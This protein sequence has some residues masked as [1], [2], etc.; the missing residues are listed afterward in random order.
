MD[1]LK[2]SKSKKQATWKQEQQTQKAP[3]FYIITPTKNDRK[4]N[5]LHRSIMW[6]IQ[7][8]LPRRVHRRKLQRQTKQ[9]RLHKLMHNQRNMDD[10]KNNSRNSKKSMNT[11][12]RP[13][14][15]NQHNQM[16]YTR[17][18]HIIDRIE[19]INPYLSDWYKLGIATTEETTLLAWAEQTLNTW[20]EEI[21]QWI[22][23]GR[24]EIIACWYDDISTYL[25][26]LEYM[27]EHQKNKPFRY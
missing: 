10:T 1:K 11:R 15:H 17:T 14:N 2:T 13:L 12:R 23:M 26:G 9:L 25:T 20:N 18:Q 7:H 4:R 21:D 27:I 19:E 3:K 8:R 6:W 22:Q 5:E 16:N 24:M